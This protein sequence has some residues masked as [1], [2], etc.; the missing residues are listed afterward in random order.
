[1]DYRKRATELANLLGKTSVDYHNKDIAIDF[2][3]EELRKPKEGFD[4]A[5]GRPY[6]KLELDR[7]GLETLVKGSY[8]AY[9][10]FDH[11]LVNKAGHSYTDFNG[12]THWDS[13]E[14]LTELELYFL[15]LVCRRSWNNN[16]TR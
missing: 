14:K 15:Y 12:K 16:K 6:L 8:P 4:Q 9:D 5:S 11:K 10:A 1:M 13:L 7:K 3:E 2:I